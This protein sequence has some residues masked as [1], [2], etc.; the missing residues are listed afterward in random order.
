MRQ[1][2]AL[3]K[4]GGRRG[5]HPF[6]SRP[7][8]AKRITVSTSLSSSAA[9]GG[10]VRAWAS[11]ARRPVAP[12]S[13]WASRSA[14]VMIRISARS[15]PRSPSPARACSTRWVDQYVAGIRQGGDP[16]AP[17][18][19]VFGGDILVG[20]FG[21]GRINAF[22]PTT[23]QFLGQLRNQ[24][25]PITVSGLWGLR[26]LPVPSTS[27]PTPNEIIGAT[28]CR[29]RARAAGCDLTGAGGRT[30]LHLRRADWWMCC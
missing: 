8:W 17:T 29:L 26:F 4:S 27:P 15:R 20:N 9:P 19:G 10:A 23:G 25:G 3:S 5:R 21:D 16:C 11:R 7:A 24:G 28:R 6:P 30:R 22:N 2:Q 13:S 14:A 18:F 12:G 1:F